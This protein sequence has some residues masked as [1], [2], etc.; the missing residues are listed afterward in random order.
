MWLHQLA[1]HRCV[2][3]SG[4]ES[5]RRGLSMQIKSQWLLPSLLATAWLLAIPMAHAQT[6]PKVWVAPSLQRIGPSDAA[7]SATQ[8][9]LWAARGEYESFQIVVSAPAGGLSNVNVSVSDLQGP[10]GQIISKKSFL[11]YRERYVYV[12][13]SR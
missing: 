13:Q 8:A 1:E 5:N 12:S 11:L 2:R 6:G 9:Q 7:G 3:Q 4:V 10:G